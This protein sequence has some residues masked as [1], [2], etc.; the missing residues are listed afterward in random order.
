MG[1]Q[2]LRLNDPGIH[3]EGWG[4]S[5]ASASSNVFAEG[6]AVTHDGKAYN[7]SRHGFQVIR[8]SGTNRVNGQKIAREGD[9]AVCGAVIHATQSTVFSD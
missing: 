3:P 9:T 4:G 1:L 7:C 8:A 2:V 6:V 5:V